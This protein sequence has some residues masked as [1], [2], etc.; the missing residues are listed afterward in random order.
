MGSFGISKDPDEM[1]G[2]YC[3]LRQK[4][5]FKDRNFILYGIDNLWHLN[6]VELQWLVQAWDHE[7]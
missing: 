1:Q 6:T 7:K 2:L 5:N 4:N 3:L